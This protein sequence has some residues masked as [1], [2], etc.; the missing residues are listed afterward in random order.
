MDA[1]LITSHTEI[2]TTMHELENEK[3]KLIEV[4][5]KLCV[6]FKEMVQMCLWCVSCL[7]REMPNV[8]LHVHRGNATVRYRDQVADGDIK[9]NGSYS[10]PFSFDTSHPL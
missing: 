3:Y 10:G 7:L 5:D 6:L 8:T 2:A 4:P 1:G 9:L